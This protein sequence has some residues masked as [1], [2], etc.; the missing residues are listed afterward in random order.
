MK[1]YNSRIKK[2]LACIIIMKVL[3]WIWIKSYIITLCSLIS[4]ISYHP[5]LNEIDY[6]FIHKIISWKWRTEPPTC[7]LQQLKHGRNCWQLWNRPQQ[8]WKITSWRT[9]CISQT[10]ALFGDYLTNQVNEDVIHKTHVSDC[11][12][13]FPCAQK[14]RRKSKCSYVACIFR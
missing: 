7:D 8:I 6:I 10:V 14:S 2:L 12:D 4:Y 13:S 1:V 9:T 5:L 11:L 3:Q